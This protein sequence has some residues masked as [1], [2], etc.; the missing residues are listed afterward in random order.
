MFG[1]EADEI[2]NKPIEYIIPS[3]YHHNHVANRD[4]FYKNPVSRQ[5]GL[6]KPLF[7]K[8]KDGV[9]FPVEISLNTHVYGEEKYIV[10]CITNV[11]NKKTELENLESINE[12]L[13]FA[14]EN[15]NK[16]LSRTLQVLELLNEKLEDAYDN[17]KAF[18]DNAKVMMFS[19]NENGLFKFFNPETVKLT[20]YSESEVVLK[21]DP[22][23]FIRKNE[24]KLCKEEFEK[25][26]NLVFKNDFDVLKEKS[27]RNEIVDLEYFFVHKNGNEFPVALSITP[28][29]NKKK[30]LTGF[31]GVAVDLTI[32][33]QSQNNLLEALSK[34][35]KL[36]ELKSRFVSMASHEFR[37][38]LSTILSSAYLIE[39]Y[40][41]KDDQPKREKHLNRIV[42]AVN[43][44][45]NILNE[46]LSV[47][48]IEEGKIVTHLTECSINNFLTALLKEIKHT[49][50]KGQYLNLTHEGNE[51]VIT[52]QNLLKNIMLNLISNAIKFSTEESK[53]D[54]KTNIDSNYFTIEVR[55]YGIGISE[56]DQGHLMERF[57]RGSNVTNIQG[58]G[59]GLHIVSKYVETLGGKL[60]FKSNLEQ[61]TSIQIIFN[62]LKLKEHE[63]NIIN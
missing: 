17:Q 19:I 35:K 18:L 57:F 63:D 4:G 16:E 55:D 43:N 1:Y 46:F 49:L 44:L 7:G 13:E 45:T 6:G 53:I 47:G 25:K 34:E 21:K 61:G 42:S 41:E 52:D 58:T 59:L 29:Y 3:R 32:R 12:N 30:Q 5:M 27:L 48:K 36:G 54:I 11:I 15:K 14:V 37:T 38:P 51:K 22:L 23:L 39:Q 60:T 62:H 26:H 24:I 40:G 28:V 33:K 31:M 8:R 56:E 9:E 2:K 20:G 50:K 10:A